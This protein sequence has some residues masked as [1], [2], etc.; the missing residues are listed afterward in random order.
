MGRVRESLGPG[1]P[2]QGNLDP[3]ALFKS[4]DKLEADVLDMLEQGTRWP[5]YIFN[6]GHGV[7]QK[8]P[9]QNVRLLVETVQ[10]YRIP[11]AEKAS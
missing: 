7:H 1:R 5:G 4:P 2:V 8:T 9:V 6:L 3:L 11:H 10:N